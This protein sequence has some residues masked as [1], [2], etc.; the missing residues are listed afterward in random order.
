M[1]KHKYYPNTATQRMLTMPI[2]SSF[3][4]TLARAI[5]ATI[6]NLSN[7]TIASETPSL[8]NSNV[9]RG[10]THMS[11]GEAFVTAIKFFDRQ[12]VFLIALLRLLIA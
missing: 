10:I 11:P 7:I 5:F 1:A 8:D 3:A 12:K 6:T 4:S 9:P 2:I